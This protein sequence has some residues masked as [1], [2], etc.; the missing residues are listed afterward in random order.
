MF[1]TILNIFLDVRSTVTQRP[2]SLEIQAVTQ[3]EPSS[4]YDI[5]LY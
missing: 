5:K 1:F 2:S 3:G 4:K